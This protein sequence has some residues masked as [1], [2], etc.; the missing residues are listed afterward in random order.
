MNIEDTDVMK[1]DKRRKEV[2]GLR[3]AR[4]WGADLFIIEPCRACLAAAKRRGVTLPDPP[5]HGI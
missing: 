2:F 5:D 3:P 1:A 4:G